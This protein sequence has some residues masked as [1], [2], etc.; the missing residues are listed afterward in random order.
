MRLTN[1]AILALRGSGMRVKKRLAAA[2]GCVSIATIN[3]WIANN[4]DTLTKA[5]VLQVIREETGLLDSEI[6]EGSEEVVKVRSLRN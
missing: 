2:G 4:D 3:R 5:A 1:I 6:L